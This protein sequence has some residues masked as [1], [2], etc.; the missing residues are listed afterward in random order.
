MQALTLDLKKLDETRNYF[1]E[2]IRHSGLIS[3]KHRKTCKTLNYIEHLLNTSTISRCIPSSAFASLVGFPLG[4]T[5]STVGLKICVTTA[6]IKKCK[7][8]IKKKNDKIVF[9]AKTKLNNIDVF[10]SKSLADSYIS[11][12]E[13]VLINNV[14]KEYEEVKVKI[15]NRNKNKYV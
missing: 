2:E 13:Y 6:G 15:R 9:L 3:K 12:A 7:S 11:H 8:V 4:I 1:L 5:N 10:I 14:L